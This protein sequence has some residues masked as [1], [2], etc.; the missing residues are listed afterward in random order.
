MNATSKKTRR[1]LFAAAAVTLLASVAPAPAA[2]GE[3]AQRMEARP[4]MASALATAAKTGKP[5]VAYFSTPQSKWCAKMESTSFAD[6]RVMTVAA[7][8]VWVKIP[9][10][11]IEQLAARH[12]VLG[13]PY[14]LVMNSR[15]QVVARR[16]GY[17]P[18][19]E[20]RKFLREGFAVATEQGAGG[21]EALLTRIAS[22]AKVTGA[23]EIRIALAGVVRRLAKPDRSG[24]RELL[25][26]LAKAGPA[27]RAAMLAYMSNDRL[28]I[29]AAAGEALGY[30][31]GEPLPFDPFALAKTRT[32]QIEAWRK[33]LKTNPNAPGPKPTPPASQPAAKAD[34]TGGKR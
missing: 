10:A 26:A 9:A 16:G 7:K 34:N 29:R 23:D 28:A 22:L 27:M 20:L 18:P 30:L 15:G 4:D 21:V 5:I 2:V 3:G 11:E 8:F 6:R 14:L 31:T 25:D 32:A 24:R 33:W 1:L 13:Y 12:G 19:A 17:L